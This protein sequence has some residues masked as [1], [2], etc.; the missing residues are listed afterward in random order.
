MGEI[1]ALT[2]EQIRAILELAHARRQRDHVAILVGFWHGLRAIEITSLTVGDVSGGRII[3]ARAKH[4]KKTAHD[5]RTYPDPLLNERQVVAEYIQGKANA[6][7]I[8]KVSVRQFERLFKSYALA[9][10]IIPAD[11]AH[12][13][14][15]KH[16]IARYLMAKGVEIQQLQQYLGHYDLRSTSMYLKVTDEEAD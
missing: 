2:L 11:K 7:R 13:H 9:T 15:L 8:I 12:P 3:V 10:G 4:S 6:D 1:A 16:S 14:V 5:L